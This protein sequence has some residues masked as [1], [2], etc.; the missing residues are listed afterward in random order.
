MIRIHY[1]LVKQ[2]N[3][4]LVEKVCISCQRRY[5]TS[6]IFPLHSDLS[7]QGFLSLIKQVEVHFSILVPKSDTNPF[8][9][10]KN[11]NIYKPK[12]KVVVSIHFTRM[13]L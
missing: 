4:F 1:P 13:L 9:L 2:G 6:T 12:V 11:S 5:I 7:I 10:E 8:N 3:I